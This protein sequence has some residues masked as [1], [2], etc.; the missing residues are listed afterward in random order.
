ME[1]FIVDRGTKVSLW[2]SVPDGAMRI[3]QIMIH[4][5]RFIPEIADSSKSAR[6]GQEFKFLIMSG[7]YDKP[8]RG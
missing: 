6:L 5:I 4:Q 8:H 1:D 7:P 3:D 2:E